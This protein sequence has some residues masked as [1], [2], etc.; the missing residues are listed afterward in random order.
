MKRKRDASHGHSRWFTRGMHRP[1]SGY[2]GYSRQTH[3]GIT[4]GRTDDAVLFGCKKAPEG[5]W[6]AAPRDFEDSIVG[7]THC[8]PHCFSSRASVPEFSLP[9]PTRETHSQSK[10]PTESFHWEMWRLRGKPR[11]KEEE[12]ERGEGE[13]ERELWHFR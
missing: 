4:V 5:F 11:E 1:L 7:P 12:R 8:S 13:R 9:T 2:V 10:Q 3:A 6:Q